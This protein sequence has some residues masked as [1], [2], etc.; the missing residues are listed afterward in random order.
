MSHFPMDP[1]Q[2]WPGR[3]RHSS[4]HHPRDSRFAVSG[5]TNRSSR[6]G[7][8]PRNESR[9]HDWITDH[10]RHYARDSRFAVSGWTDRSSGVVDSQFNDSRINNW[11]PV[12]PPYHPQRF[13]EERRPRRQSSSPVDDYG[14]RKNLR[15][16]MVVLPPSVQRESRL[17]N[18]IPD[19]PRYH[20][21]RFVRERGPRRQNSD[22]TDEYP[23]YPNS[24]SSEVVLPPLPTIQRH[25]SR[26]KLLYFIRPQ[27]GHPNRR[28]GTLGRLTDA[29]TGEGPDVF[30]TST[31]RG[32]LM[33][34]RP[35][36]WQWS[37]H[38]PDIEEILTRVVEPDFAWSEL[39]P[40]RE[41]PW[42]KRDPREKY[43]CRKRRY[44]RTDAQWDPG[45]GRVTWPETFRGGES[46]WYRCVL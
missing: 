21:K 4:E 10:R 7:D 33:R 11:I 38:G 1:E 2:P 16:S 9:I 31:T 18:W 14:W 5:S 35:Q 45:A 32:R 12:L 6:A 26:K 42:A 36:R 46:R 29:L 8:P 41:T 34:D 13:V 43:D 44:V 19:D 24:R 39:A 15:S 30:V 3:R 37:G 17:Y 25:K 27:D 23:W 28:R 40:V 20:S 22:L